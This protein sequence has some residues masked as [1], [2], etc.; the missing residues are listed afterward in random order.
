MWPLLHKIYFILFFGSEIFDIFCRKIVNFN[1]YCY[2][3]YF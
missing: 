2:L 3:G 1:G